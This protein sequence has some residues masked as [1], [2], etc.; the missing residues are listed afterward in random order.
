M[1][2]YHDYRASE[3]D[4]K[5]KYDSELMFS[6]DAVTECLESERPKAIVFDVTVWPWI[7]KWAVARDKTLVS[8]TPQNVRDGR[9]GTVDQ[10]PLISDNVA[11]SDDPK[12]GQGNLLILAQDNTWSRYHFS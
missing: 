7:V 9:V 6:I 1:E 3:P 8:P 5:F 11:L 2:S 12:I 4:I 10:I